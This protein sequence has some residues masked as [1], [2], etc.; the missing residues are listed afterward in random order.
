MILTP[1]SP[2]T[3]DRMYASGVWLD[4]P[5]SSDDQRTSISINNNNNNRKWEQLEELVV[6]ATNGG[7][8]PVVH[9]PVRALYNNSTDNKFNPVAYVRGNVALRNV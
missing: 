1:V 4:D 3:G 5:S 2:V 6:M 8:L 9:R 7:S